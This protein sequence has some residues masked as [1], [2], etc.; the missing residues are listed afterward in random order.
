MKSYVEYI[1]EVQNLPSKPMV[2]LT[3]PVFTCSD[4]PED[5]WS[6]EVQRQIFT[7]KISCSRVQQFDL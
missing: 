4:V 1:E 2:F 3:V 6:E 7:T 5:T